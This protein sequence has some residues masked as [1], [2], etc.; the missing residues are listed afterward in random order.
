M[1]AYV[2]S[3][4]MFEFAHPL[5]GLAYAG[6][7]ERLKLHECAAIEVAQDSVGFGVGHYAAAGGHVPILRWLVKDLGLPASRGANVEIARRYTVP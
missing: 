6:D 1:L 2:K 4:G 5:L 3:L 7:L